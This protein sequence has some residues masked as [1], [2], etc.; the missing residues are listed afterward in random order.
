MVQTLPALPETRCSGLCNFPNLP[1]HPLGGGGDW[2]TKRQSTRKNYTTGQVHFVHWNNWARKPLMDESM[3]RLSGR[4]AYFP[5]QD[6]R[7]S[8]S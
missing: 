3:F 1:A 4:S 8:E 5:R 6:V 2:E 7:H